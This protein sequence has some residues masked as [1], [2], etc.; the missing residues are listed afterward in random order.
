MAMEPEQTL[1]F[2]Q[3]YF[4]KINSASN[5]F[6]YFFDW[7]ARTKF[8]MNFQHFHQFYE[9]HILLNTLR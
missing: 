3:G 2:E 1:L 7:D 4:I 8:N 5:P 6:Y 9:I